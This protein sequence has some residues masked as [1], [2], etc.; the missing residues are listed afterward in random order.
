MKKKSV[1]VN[2]LVLLMATLILCS[3]GNLASSTVSST[4]ESKSSQSSEADDSS[5]TS[6]DADNADSLAS[7]SSDSQSIAA[8]TSSEEDTSSDTVT[9][10]TTDASTT[11]C[12]HCGKTIEELCVSAVNALRNQMNDTE[13][14][15]I[16]GD[17]LTLNYTKYD[18][19]IISLVSSGK[20]S[21]GA[22]VGKQDVAIWLILEESMCTT[23]S[24]GFYMDIRTMYEEALTTE[25]YGDPVETDYGVFEFYSGEEVASVVGAEY[26]DY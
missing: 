26:Y 19:H 14:L 10:N 5:A 23:E 6:S 17:I 11:E 2:M 1:F 25:G 24:S 9:S 4:E 3:C 12:Q 15:R 7:G 22:Y 20:N 21:L 13:S 16:Y 18:T 8:S